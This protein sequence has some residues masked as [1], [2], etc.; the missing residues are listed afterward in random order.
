MWISRIA[1]LFI[2]GTLSACGIAIN[3]VPPTIDLGTKHI[4]EKNYT[5]GSPRSAY[6]GDAI[7]SVKDYYTES[8]RLS[9]MRPT[10]DFIFPAAPP[11]SFSTTKIYPIV[12][13]Y[14]RDNTLFNV[15]QADI[16]GIN[17]FV[18]DDGHIHNK[19]IVRVNDVFVIPILERL[20][21]PSNARM[22]LVTETKLSSTSGHINYQLIYNGTD[23]KSIF[24]TYREFTPDDLAKT[25]FYQ[26]L[27][28][29]NAS[30]SIRFKNISIDVFTAN[31]ERIDYAVKAE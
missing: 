24:L 25:A 17:L 10:I 6:V 15:V 4:L 22:T 16:G 23:G 29:S 5:L 2:A 19:W 27:T 28:Y 31:N 9:G 8:K 14:F 7:V 1:V 18:S 11:V 20:P 12:G 26:N 3:P 13:T 30:K 21:E